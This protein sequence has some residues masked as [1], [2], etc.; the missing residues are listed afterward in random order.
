MKPLCLIWE[1][2]E[3]GGV[4]ALYYK[5]LIHEYVI[6]TVIGE[7]LFFD[8]TTNSITLDGETS[9]TGR[10]TD[11]TLP[12]TSISLG[13]V[14]I[15]DIDGNTFIE[16]TDYIVDYDEGIINRIPQQGIPLKKTVYCA[17]QWRTHCVEISTGNPRR[18]CPQCGG[19][20]F[21]WAEPVPIIGLMHIPSYSSP[22]SKIGYYEEG[23]MEFTVPSNKDLG[24]G[25]Q[26]I[27]NLFLRD[28][29]DVAGESWRI[30]YKPQTI[31][32]QNQYIAKKL[33][34]RRLKFT[35]GV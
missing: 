7:E 11:W 20:G 9:P 21:V 28:R 22:Y 31:Q 10:T 15:K 3:R 23:D 19:K 2:I 4:D 30:M 1:Q 26:G 35:P 6:Y 17:Y 29:I 5:A 34:L 27:D 33:H 14:M 16:N 24:V 12:D 13:T 25:P 8:G 32:M 18:N